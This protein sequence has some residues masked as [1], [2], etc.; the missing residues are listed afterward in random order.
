MSTLSIINMYNFRNQKN[1]ES[2]F[3]QLRK[4]IEQ[5]K[6]SVSIAQ[7]KVQ[8]LSMACPHLLLHPHLSYVPTSSLTT[9]HT[10]LLPQSLNVVNYIIFA[11]I[12]SHPFPCTRITFLS[13]ALYLAMSP[14]LRT[15]YP[16]P[17]D[18]G[19]WP[20]ECKQNKATPNRSPQ[21]HGTFPPVLLIFLYATRIPYLT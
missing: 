15:I 17:I 11:V 13:T 7:C 3:S 14:V 2:I 8:I 12:H 18:F 20:K 4:E 21:S 10:G 19:L 6:V 9:S 16:C 5:V 1:M